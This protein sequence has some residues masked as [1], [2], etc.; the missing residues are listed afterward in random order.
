MDLQNRISAALESLLEEI[1]DEKWITSGDVT[2]GQYLEWERITEETA[3]LFAELIEQ[4]K[5][6]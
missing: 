1:Y 6:L 3:A 4:N 5:P 2:P